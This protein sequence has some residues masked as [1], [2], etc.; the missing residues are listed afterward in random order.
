M[1]FLQELFSSSLQKQITNIQIP[2]DDLERLLENESIQMIQSIHS[3]LSDDTLSDP[4]CFL[5]IEEIIRVF[6]ERGIYC[7]NRHDF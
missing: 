6:E 5:K 7:G 4:E 2:Y 1:K 3:I